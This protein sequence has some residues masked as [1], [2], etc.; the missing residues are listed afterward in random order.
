MNSAADTPEPRVSDRPM[1]RRGLVLLRGLVWWLTFGEDDLWRFATA[2]GKSLPGWL[3]YRRRAAGRD[4]PRDHCGSPRAHSGTQGCRARRR[5]G[6]IAKAS[7][8]AGN[9]GKPWEMTS[10]RNRGA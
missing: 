6:R 7:G 1:P 2:M 9:P 4:A 10:S 3:L 5:L 8:G